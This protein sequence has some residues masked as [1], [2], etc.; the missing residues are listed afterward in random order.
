[1]QLEQF[2]KIQEAIDY[3]YELDLGKYINEGIEIFKKNIGNFAGYTAVFFGIIM[4]SAIIPFIGTIAALILT[5]S[6]TVGFYLVA[7]KLQRN[8][9]TQFSDFFKGFDYIGQLLLWY[10]VMALILGLMMLPFIAGVMV[11][12]FSV[13]GSSDPSDIPT[14]VWG[15]TIFFIPVIYFSIAWR[16]APMFIVF[17]G[18]NFW[19]A[20]ETS[21][22]L[23]T[24]KWWMMFLLAM[25]IG[26]LGSIG[27]VA[28]LVGFLF[29]YP[30]AMCIDYMAFANVT[31]LHTT[32]HSDED[33]V[34]HL[35]D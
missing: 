16:W 14:Y 12:A 3:G 32:A 21:R 7:H 29:T 35:V 24:K 2:P 33:I 10:L 15:L 30:M 34:A 5:P 20:M 27:Y 31:G 26:I 23:I 17:Y 19:E 9:G 13:L 18:M 6:L 4:V 25:I 22:K 11:S 8:E 28:L 1:M